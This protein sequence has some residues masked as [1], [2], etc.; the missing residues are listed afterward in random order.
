MTPVSRKVFFSLL[1]FF[2]TKSFC[3]ASNFPSVDWKDLSDRKL[4]ETGKAALAVYKDAWQHSETENFVYHYH[5]PKEAETVLIHTEVYYQWA[6]EMFGVSKIPKNFKG[7][8]HIFVFDDKALWKSFNQ[9]TPEKLPGAE[10]FTNGLELFIYREPFWLAPQRVLAHEI[11]HLVL[12]RFVKGKV[13]LFLNEGFAEFMATKAI[14]MKADGNDFNVRTFQLVPESQFIPMQEFILM[15]SYPDTEAKNEIFYRQSE[16]FT[17]FL[18]LNYPKEKFY[19]LLKE[20]ASGRPFEKVF[21]EIYG[22]GLE[23]LSEKFK[24]YAMTRGA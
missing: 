13:P 2:T 8:S 18:A 19:A 17:R 16:L 24:T 22:F 4:T 5:D 11:T 7:K 23:E 20:T 15:Q 3:F 6:K 14:A 12:F 9:T 1:L 10:A 21:K